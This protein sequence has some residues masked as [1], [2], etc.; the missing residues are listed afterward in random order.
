MRRYV[1][2]LEKA[3][4]VKLPD[5]P[6]PEFAV[7]N[8][9]EVRRMAA[10]GIEFGAHTVTHPILSQLEDQEEAREEIAVSKTRME[11]AIDRPVRH[12]AYPSGRLQD[13]SPEI[14][15]FVRDAGC[16]TSVTTT[17]GQVFAGDDA[18]LLKRIGLTADM[19]WHRCCQ[20]V[21]AFRP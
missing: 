10:N 5:S 6:T 1:S 12:F 4:E 15:K 20:R 2:L 16:E 8:W 13:Y 11:A 17:A 21:A 3:L 18:Y 14:S 9:T 7:L 19:P